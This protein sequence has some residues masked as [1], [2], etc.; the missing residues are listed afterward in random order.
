MSELIQGFLK[1]TEDQRDIRKSWG[2]TVVQTKTGPGFAGWG[3][4]SY[5]PSY[6]LDQIGLA[7]AQVVKRD[8]YQPPTVTLASTF[9]PVWLSGADDSILNSALTSVRG[10]VTLNAD[11]RPQESPDYKH[12][13]LMIFLNELEN[14]SAAGALMRLSERKQA[15]PN[16][17]AMIAVSQGPLFCLAVARSVMVGRPSYESQGSMQRFSAGITAVLQTHYSK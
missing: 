16:E 2:Y 1:R 11:L 13:S 4:E 17:F 15:R 6:P 7:L 8:K 10:T 9:P 12:Q 14:E 3:F 5:Q